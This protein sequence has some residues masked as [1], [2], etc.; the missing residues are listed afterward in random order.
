MRKRTDNNEIIL[1]EDYAELI[2]YNRDQSEKCRAL[3][4][5]NKIEL[6]SKFRWWLTE[7]GYVRTKC[8]IS[9]DHIFLHRLILGLG[10]GIYTDHIN[11]NKLDNRMQN[12]RPCNKSQNS[13]NRNEQFNNSSGYTGV[14]FDKRRNRF[15][16]RI[17]VNGH[18]IF[19]GYFDSFVDAKNARMT[20]EETYFKEFKRERL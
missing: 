9:G 12:L 15:Y 19:L 17:K 8:K 6:V 11:M 5:I 1:K 20:A 14:C 4:D 2:L 18:V 10:D 13:M 7:Y 16:S 3:I